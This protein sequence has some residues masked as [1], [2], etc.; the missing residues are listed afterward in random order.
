[1]GSYL[2]LLLRAETTLLDSLLTVGAGHRAEAEVFSGCDTL[3]R[4]SREHQRLLAPIVARYQQQT[5]AETEEPDP[6]HPEAITEVRSGPVGLLR[7]LQGLYLL[8]TLVQTSWTVVFQG[9][10]GARDRE[11]MDLAEQCSG[12]TS[13]Q[14]SWLNTHLKVAAPQALLV[15]S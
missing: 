6:F 11:L 10:Q 4:M 8:A 13:R 9:A 1:M 14:L 12:E 7:D 2:R 15:A 5:D 3:A